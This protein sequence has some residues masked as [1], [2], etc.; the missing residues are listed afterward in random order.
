MIAIHRSLT[1][2]LMHLINRIDDGGLMVDD[3][4]AGN[5]GKSRMS[6]LARLFVSDM[7]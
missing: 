7:V 2:K 3:G 4:R 5:R 1:E 6:F